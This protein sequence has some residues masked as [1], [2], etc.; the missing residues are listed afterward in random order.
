[1]DEIHTDIFRISVALLVR[2]GI[3]MSCVGWQKTEPLSQLNLPWELGHITY[4]LWAMVSSN[5]RQGHRGCGEQRLGVRVKEGMVMFM[6][7]RSYKD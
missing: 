7:S 5:V 3:L 6:G 2:T 1:M 4:S